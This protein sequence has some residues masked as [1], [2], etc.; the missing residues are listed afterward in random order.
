MKPREEVLHEARRAYERGRVAKAMR[1]SLLVLPM[2][3]VSFGCCGNRSASI[4]FAGVLVALVASL[5]WRGGDVGR[6]VVPG[7]AAGAVPLGIALLAC[8]ACDRVGVSGTW[9]MAICVVGGVL[10]G[11]MV[12]RFAARASP[13]AS[14][15][16]SDQPAHARARRA[17]FLVTAGAVAALA[18]SLGC[19]VMGAGGVAAMA[20]GLALIA[21]PFGLLPARG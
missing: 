12:A 7:L 20:A 17:T 4:A 6:A 3:L 10:S 21:V 15:A 5:V 19:V 14:H 9:P 1:T 2:I 11:A 16:T 18:G 8:P 13:D